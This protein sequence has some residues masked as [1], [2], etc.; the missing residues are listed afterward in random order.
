MLTGVFVTIGV[1]ISIL[2]AIYGRSYPI[3]WAT[4]F[5]FIGLVIL[6]NYLINERRTA[7][8]ELAMCKISAQL[9]FSY[10]HT[11]P[12]PLI[13]HLNVIKRGLGEKRFDLNK[14]KNVM[15]GRF[16]NRHVAVFD[17]TYT[18]EVGSSSVT[19]RETIFLVIS[20]KLNLPNLQIEEGRGGFMGNALIE[21]F[22]TRDIRFS[23]RPDFTKK[24]QLHGGDE[25]TL[26]RIFTPQIIKFYEDEY[27]LQTLAG[28]NLLCIFLPRESEEASTFNEIQTWLNG[29]MRL[30]DLFAQV[31]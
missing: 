28:G 22:G 3:S 6:L 23:D 29:L 18:V 13:A 30:H 17:H 1:L 10:S 7:E 14:T 15:T 8:R 27:P 19:E 31:R 4:P 12:S 21:L 25:A 5:V 2:P 24:Y 11:P 26:R 9:G 20:D 16:N